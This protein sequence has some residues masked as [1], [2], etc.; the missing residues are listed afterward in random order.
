[1]RTLIGVK[2]GCWVV[3]TASASV[4]EVDLDNSTLTRQPTPR[5]AEPNPLRRD[6]DRLRLLDIV[7]LSVGSPAIF[8]VDL[9]H[10]GVACTTRVTTTVVSINLVGP[11]VGNS[12]LSDEFTH[13]VGVWDDVPE[14]KRGDVSE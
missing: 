8:L 12:S 4:Y 6:G 1:M 14:A 13:V 5:A 2:E 11:G 3:K 9:D 7:A 10:F